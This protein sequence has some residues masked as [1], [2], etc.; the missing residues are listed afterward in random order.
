MLKLNFCISQKHKNIYSIFIVKVSQMDLV[1][2]D[3]KKLTV[4]I[5]KFKNSREKVSTSKNLTY[6]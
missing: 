4:F 6:P 1:K 5:L 3:L 2:N